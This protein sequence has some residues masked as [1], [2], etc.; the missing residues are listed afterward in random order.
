MRYKS[1]FQPLTLFRL[2]AV[3]LV[4]LSP[5]VPAKASIFP[6]FP[7]TTQENS[8][9]NFWFFEG[10]QLPPLGEP[11]LYLPSEE[12]TP[13]ESINNDINTHLVVKLSDRQV[14]V[15]QNNQLKVS[16]PIAVGKPGWETPLGRYQ[17]L[18]MQRNPAWQHPWNDKVIPP[19]P[20]NPLGARWIGFW[21]DGR[22]FIG[23]H[24]TPN[25]RLVGQAVSH[26]CIRMRNQDILALYALVKIGTPVT[27]EP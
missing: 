19:G 15:Y 17:V 25:E 3:I 4:L 13:V 20:D 16:Y 14:Y 21:T 8:P 10:L 9:Q 5:Q 7:D 1:Q 23:F 6:E 2:S 27:V 22:N 11:S 24:G 12:I 26:G 18:T